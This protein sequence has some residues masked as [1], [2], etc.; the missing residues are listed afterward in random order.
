MGTD[1][2]TIVREASRLLDDEGAYQDMARVQNPYGDGKTSER[3]WD[4]IK[5]RFS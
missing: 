5:K 3:I 1:R 2:G 4:I